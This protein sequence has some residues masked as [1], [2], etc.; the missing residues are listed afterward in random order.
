MENINY[1]EVIDRVGYFRNKANL[2]MRELSLRLGM[3]AQFMKTIESRQIELKVKTLLDICD[4]VGISILDFF[5]LGKNYSSADKEM[6]GLFNSLSA[7]NKNTIVELMKK[8]K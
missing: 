4:E 5:Y 8:L 1:D 3:N 6:L 2:S 7:E